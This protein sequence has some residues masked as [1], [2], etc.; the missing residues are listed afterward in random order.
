MKLYQVPA[1]WRSNWGQSQLTVQS[2]PNSAVGEE[3]GRWLGQDPHPGPQ[4]LDD[5]LGALGRV[6]LQPLTSK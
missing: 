3:G 5:P 1:C 4:E 2:D 6:C